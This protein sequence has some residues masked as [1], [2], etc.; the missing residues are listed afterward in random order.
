M[1]AITNGDSFAAIMLEQAK[2]HQ[3]AL[4]ERGLSDTTHAELMRFTEESLQQQTQLEED[5][6]HSFDEFLSQY[7]A[8]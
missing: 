1:Q 7:H 4:R 6:V 8:V 3:T 2:K 5:D